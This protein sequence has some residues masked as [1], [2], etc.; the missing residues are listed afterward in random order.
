[1][2]FAALTKVSTVLASGT[3]KV[4]YLRVL[5]RG[6]KIIRVDLRSYS[7]VRCKCHLESYRQRTADCE[8]VFLFRYAIRNL[9]ER[10]TE[11][12]RK[13]RI[14]WTTSLESTGRG[15]CG[16]SSLTSSGRF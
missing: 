4:V 10:R 1:M 7:N 2:I 16:R 5:P 3:H 14:P 11:S 8:A 9:P 6:I 15:P 13:F 12:Q